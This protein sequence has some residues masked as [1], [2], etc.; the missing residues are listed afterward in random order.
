VAVSVGGKG[1]EVA[2]GAGR[3]SVGGASVGEG[4]GELDGAVVADAVGNDEA[5]GLGSRVGV[6]RGVFVA[7]ANTILVLVGVGVSDE[8]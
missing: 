2:E 6:G 5:V 7:K 3:V 4:G 1:L 8:S